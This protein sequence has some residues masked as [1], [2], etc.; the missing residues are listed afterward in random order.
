MFFLC[1]WT[2]LYQFSTKNLHE[3]LQ[4]WLFK[5]L[6]KSFLLNLSSR[7]DLHKSPNSNGLKLTI[8]EAT[9]LW[10]R[11]YLVILK[12]SQTKKAEFKAMSNMAGKFKNSNGLEFGFLSLTGLFK[13][14]STQH[15]LWF[16]ETV[17]N[18]RL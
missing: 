3:K 16:F 9:V 4:E 10:C 11:P 7:L 13:K 17:H 2:R 12:S 15:F 1:P 18:V 6:F 14:I 8:K 5:I